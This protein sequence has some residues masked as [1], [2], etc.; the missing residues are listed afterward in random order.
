MNGIHTAKT[1][2]EVLLGHADQ[3]DEKRLITPAQGD[4]ARFGTRLTA[5]PSRR[6]S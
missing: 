3:A 5:Q 4:V 2:I 6:R 1:P